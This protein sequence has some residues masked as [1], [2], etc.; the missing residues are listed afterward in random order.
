MFNQSISLVE[1]PVLY[2]ILY[3]I[4]DLLKFNIYNYPLTKDFVKEIN[5]GSLE[6]NSSTI[7]IENKNHSLFLVQKLNKKNILVFDRRPL[8][9]SYIIDEIN[10]QL[11]K[12][13]YKFQS[14]LMVKNYFLDLNSRA[15]SNKFGELKL[16][17]KEMD[18]ILSHFASNCLEDMTLDRLSNYDLLTLENDHDLYSWVTG[19]AKPPQKF[20]YLINEI[21]E[22]LGTLQ[23]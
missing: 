18:I 9:I 11:I 20:S 4:K 15:I 22:N 6:V 14:K 7:I 13:K 21:L 3:E 19:T 23:D 12:Q 17:E 2:S 10:T 1:F 5:N 8:K 16:T